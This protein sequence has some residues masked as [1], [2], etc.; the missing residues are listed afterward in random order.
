M[1]VPFVKMQALGNDFVVLDEQ[2]LGRPLALDADL[3]R[4][5]CDRRIGVGADQILWLRRPEGVAETRMEVFN[6]DGSRSGMC[7]NGLRAVALYLSRRAPQGPG[8]R[9]PY[10]I[11]T[12]DRVNVA[13]VS[14]GGEA[15]VEMGVPKVAPA[16]EEL[17]ALG[18]RHRFRAVDVG[19][20]HAV[21]FVP[22][23]ARAEAGRFGPAI[24]RHPRFPDRANVEFAAPEGPGAL[25]VVVWER[26]AG[27]TQACG[28]G[29]AASAAAAIASGRCRSPVEVRLPGGAVTVHWDGSGALRLEGPAAEVFSGELEA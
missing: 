24:E 20:P 17:E 8:G 28:S 12:L 5:I 21:I 1:K 25:R 9:G 2:R 6:A 11:E 27:L 3:A 26:G 7:G 22:D 13:T 4:R 14:A 15:S 18:S 16:D 10:R 29:A 23:P 19:N